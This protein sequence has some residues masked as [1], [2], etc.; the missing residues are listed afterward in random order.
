MK[1]GFL[2]AASITLA[3]ALTNAWSAGGGGGGGAGGGAGG[4]GAGGGN[5][6]VAV[7]PDFKAGMDAVKKQN[8]KQAIARMNAYTER[9]AGN[10]DAWNELGHAYRKVG[11]M[12]NSFKN[13][14][15]A[16]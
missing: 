5:E 1:Y 6:S 2:T 16:L 11:D 14:A 13:Y 12:D 15:K 10:A 4:G 8:W 7:D 3:I 9:N